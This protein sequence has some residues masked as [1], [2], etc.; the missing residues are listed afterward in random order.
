VTTDETTDTAEAGTE[1][2]AAREPTEAAG[3]TLVS[4]LHAVIDRWVSLTAPRLQGELDYATIKIT[5]SD[6]GGDDDG[7]LVVDYRVEE[8]TSFDS[9]RWNH[10]GGR[11]P[12]VEY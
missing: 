3:D 5:L 7:T 6:P 9:E 8:E 10:G 2:A 12:G 1:Q 11:V 4:K